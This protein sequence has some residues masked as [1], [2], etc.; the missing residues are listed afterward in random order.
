MSYQDQ[1]K[2][3]AMTGMMNA[4]MP[5]AGGGAELNRTPTPV[6]G[7]VKL[8]CA[9]VEEAHAVLTQL[10]D[11]L[12]SGGVLIDTV[13]DKTL[14]VPVPIQAIKDSDRPQCRLEYD[15][16]TQ[17]RAVYELAARMNRIIDTLGV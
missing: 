5:R 12:S 15:I 13:N 7:A 9:R 6:E 16:E 1:A 10:N 14:G 8:L 17:V 4:G 3:A 2:I 11:R